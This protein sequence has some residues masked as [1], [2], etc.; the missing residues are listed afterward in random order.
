[1]TDEAA[2]R[3]RALDFVRQEAG[4]AQLVTLG[5]G[6]ALVGR[7]TSAFPTDDWAVEL[8]QRRTHRRVEQLRHDDRVLAIWGGTPA[9]DSVN[10]SPW[11]FDLGLTIPRVVF[12]RGVARPLD[13]KAT[14]EVYDR[15]T[16]RLRA[17][18]HTKAPLRDR[19]D[20]DA[21]F[22]GVR[23][24]PRRVRLEGFGTGAQAFSWTI[25]PRRTDT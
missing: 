5:A 14:W 18:G 3:S 25:T 8:V 11:T 10:D 2:A 6:G 1:M 12:V 9:D 20:L 13:A 21:N 15:H 23:I 22:A 24:E 19:A 4:F 16:T 7:T 17:A